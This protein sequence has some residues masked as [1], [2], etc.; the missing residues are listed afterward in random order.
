MGREMHNTFLKLQKCNVSCI[1]IFGYC[2]CWTRLVCVYAATEDDTLDHFKV[3]VRD[4]I[5][6]ACLHVKDFLCNINTTEN[7]IHQDVCDT[8]K[9]YSHYR[10]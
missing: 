3:Q 4:V 7:L 5:F 1:A 2:R 8:L 9:F 6:K 10:K